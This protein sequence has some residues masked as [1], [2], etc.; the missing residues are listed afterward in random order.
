M[1]GVSH[2]S[3]L[4][5]GPATLLQLTEKAE[6]NAVNALLRLRFDLTPMRPACRQ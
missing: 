6:V 4:P 5:T 3:A 2:Y 1:F